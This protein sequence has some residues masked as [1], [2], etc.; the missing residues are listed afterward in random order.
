VRLTAHRG[1]LWGGLAAAAVVLAAAAV[2]THARNEV[3]R[4]EESLW[5]DVTVKSPQ[6]PRGLSNYG[7][8]LLSAGDFAGGLPYLERAQALQ[9]EDAVIEVRLANA[10]AGVG[11]DAE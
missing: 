10:Y 4:T 3:W 11:R 5:R 7:N 1:W 6:N 9:P 2:G 8:L